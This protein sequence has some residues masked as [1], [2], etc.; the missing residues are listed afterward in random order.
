MFVHLSATS[1]H[2]A[3]ATGH[4]LLISFSFSI[5]LTK[6]FQPEEEMTPEERAAQKKKEI[7]AEF[8]KYKLARRAAAER[9][10]QQEEEGQ[11][12]VVTAGGEA[13]VG[14]IKDRFD[15]GE[16]FKTEGQDGWARSL[17]S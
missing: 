6:L 5:S 13:D 3:A 9:A 7:E 4:L 17:R 15:K 8:L 14:S 16:A 2:A 11:T 1:S 12:P 10:K